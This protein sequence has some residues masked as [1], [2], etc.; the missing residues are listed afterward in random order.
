MMRT[1]QARLFIHITDGTQISGYDLKVRVLPDVIFSHFKHAQVQI[2]D[3]AERPAGH[4]HYGD[5]P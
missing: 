4:E 2:G 3:W 5:L 1:K